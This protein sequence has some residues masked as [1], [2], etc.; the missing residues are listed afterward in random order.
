[1]TRKYINNRDK[2]LKKM[3][4]I[5]DALQLVAALE[6]IKYQA[7]SRITQTDKALLNIIRRIK[8]VGFM[9]KSAVM[10]TFHLNA[11]DYAT[12]RSEYLKMFPGCIFLVT[13][14]NGRRTEQWR[15]PKLN[16]FS[17]DIVDKQIDRVEQ[18]LDEGPVD[19]PKPKYLPKRKRLPK[20]N[21]PKPPP[22]T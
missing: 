2:Q 18:L 13:S 4:T 19:I 10:Q 21:Q 16:Y 5:I 17:E 15:R 3:K 12:V 20:R 14:R 22:A 9:S 7:P 11:K 8:T 1:M 6:D